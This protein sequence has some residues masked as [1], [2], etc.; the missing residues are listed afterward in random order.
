MIY[1]GQTSALSALPHEIGHFFGLPHSNYAD[2]IMN[3]RRRMHP[4]EEERSFARREFAFIKR[5]LGR[6]LRTR[7]LH[8]R[9]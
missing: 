3:K 2:S 1:L 5:K 7:E 4:P 8:A 9:Q 6:M